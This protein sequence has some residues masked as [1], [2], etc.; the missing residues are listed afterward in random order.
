MLKK[1][2]YLSVFSAGV[3]LFCASPALAVTPQEILNNSLS[4]YNSKDGYRIVG[5]MVIDVN[6]TR[7]ASAIKAG[8]E[9][10]SFTLDFLS[11][12][13]PE[14]DGQQDSE[15]QLTLSK[16]SLKGDGQ[17]LEMDEP[18]SFQWKNV[19]PYL[20]G[21]IEKMPAVIS[22]LLGSDM[23]LSALVGQ[24]FKM[25]A[26]EDM[27]GLSQINDQTQ[28]IDQMTEFFQAMADKKALLVARTEKKYKNPAGDDM[29][30][31][32]LAINRG[33][34]YKEYVNNLNQAYK[35]KA[36]KERVAKIK[37]LRAEYYKTIA[38]I[39]KISAVANINLTQNKLDRIEMGMSQKDP[40][41]EC[42]WNEKAKKSI[43][44]TIGWTNVRVIGGMTFMPVDNKPIT[45]P[46]NALDLDDW[47]NLMSI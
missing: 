4:S 26:P 28:R 20:Y 24:W 15:G 37:E 45:L 35:I 11:R 34:I 30:R 33:M 44:K 10:G 41:E 29:L 16:A 6:E 40:K 38:E 17:N 18:L 25:E 46:D 31:V 19:D 27:N 12:A 13:L 32:R 47:G 2:L 5:Q 9:S 23:D 22:G 14:K 36:Y 7:Y 21:R 1:S 43:C 8:P 42:T 39:N 3:A